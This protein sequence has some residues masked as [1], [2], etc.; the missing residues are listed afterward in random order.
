MED[1]PPFPKN[2]A[3]YLFDDGTGTGPSM[4]E[5]EARVKR[6]ARRLEQ[7][8]LRRLLWIG[9]NRPDTPVL[10]LA[11]MRA[12]IVTVPLGPD[13]TWEHIRYVLRVTG[14]DGVLTDTP[15]TLEPHL[16]HG[17]PIPATLGGR[18]WRV[19]ETDPVPSIPPETS[20]ITFTSGVTGAPR[21]VCHSA[22]QIWQGAEE[23]E[24]ALQASQYDVHVALLPL[25][26]LGAAQWTV[27]GCL[28]SAARTLL[29][30]LRRLGLSR[31]TMP[32][33]AAIA[34]SIGGLPTPQPRRWWRR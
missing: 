22:A 15:E 23:L 20:R 12:G 17:E 13:P 9:D 33:G 8:E 14:A 6:H 32:D 29:P 19:H 24:K 18:G 21:G 25:S 7:L 28:L 26:E 4:V 11:A 5:F 3:P 31:N 34:R 1:L 16:G 2:D 30:S 27:H 10:E